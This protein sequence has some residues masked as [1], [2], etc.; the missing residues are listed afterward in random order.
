MEYTPAGAAQAA[1]QPVVLAGKG[2]TFDTGGYWLKP[3][4]KLVGMKGDMAGGAVVIGAMR[5]IALLELPLPVVGLV[6]C[7]ENMIG[8][9]AYKTND[10]IIAKNGLSIEVISADAE[11]RMLLADTL[12]YAGELKP[13]TVIDIATLTSGK[14]AALGQRM[15]GL[16]CNDAKLAEALL[17][18]GRHVGEPLW[19]LPLD[20]A[21]DR[22]LESDVAD[23]KNSG[24]SVASPVT[25]AR[26][27]A[28]FVGDWP[29]A[30][31]DIAGQPFY[32]DTPEQTPRSYLTK[33]GTGIPL[34]TLVEFLRNLA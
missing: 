18:A 32:S 25:A 26:F 4:K 16:F 31:I 2:V 15:S 8:P 13:A 29:W 14:V 1:R 5:A 9:A 21:Y 12:C 22:Q 24:G 20:A 7:A 30:H 23:L 34:R 3:K 19:Q 17:R 28:H 27:L 6:P 10:V 33:G 11:G